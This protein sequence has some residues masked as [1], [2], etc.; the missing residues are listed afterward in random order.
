MKVLFDTNIL[1]DSL[2]GYSQARD[3]IKCYPDRAISV[4]SQIEMLA[5]GNLIYE[6]KVRVLLSGF[7]VFQTE[8]TIA[9]YAADI[10]RE[11]KLKI[12]DAIIVASAKF[13]RRTVIT[14]D[15]RITNARHGVACICPYVV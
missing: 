4:I 3:V 12:A 13:A 15:A 6:A 10:R 2:N 5:G 1:I 7:T 14:R 11:H 9:E 8:P